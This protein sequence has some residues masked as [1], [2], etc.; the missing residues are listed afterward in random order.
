MFFFPIVITFCSAVHAVGIT[1]DW[2]GNYLYWTD[3]SKLQVNAV[4][5]FGGSYTSLVDVRP[6]QP[7]AIAVDPI[8]E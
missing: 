2:I 8:T 6:F 7:T 5:F 1:V 3:Y 4:D